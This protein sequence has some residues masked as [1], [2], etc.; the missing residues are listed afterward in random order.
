MKF[1]DLDDYK[2]FIRASKIINGIAELYYKL[3]QPADK[4]NARE[5][6]GWGRVVNIP[7]EEEV[8]EIK[9]KTKQNRDEFF[10]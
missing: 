7:P 1:K 10:T 4:P 6:W 8:I 3:W 9:G 5:M 2:F